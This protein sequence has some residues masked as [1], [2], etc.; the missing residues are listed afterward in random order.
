MEGGPEGEAQ[1]LAA[2]QKH[3]EGIRT[4]DAGRRRICIVFSF[5]VPES[6]STQ[7]YDHVGRGQAPAVSIIVNNDKADQTGSLE[8]RSRCLLAYDS[9]AYLKWREI[10]ATHYLHSIQR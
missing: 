6:G 8:P 9:L 1:R 2:A 3:P 7:Q 10:P 4:I 5:S